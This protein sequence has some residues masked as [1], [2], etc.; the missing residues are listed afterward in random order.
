MKTQKGET[1]LKATF[2]VAACA[3]CAASLFATAASAQTIKIGTLW[4]YSG[5]NGNLGEIGEHGMRLYMQQHESD[6]PPGVKVKL[7]AGV[8]FT[9]NA[10]AIAPLATEAKMPFVVM[11]A[12]TSM[13]TTKSPFIVRT[14]FT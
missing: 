5:L 14:S 4:A 1:M 12:G 10:L 3:A 7:L 9:P 6:L 8:I 13:I 2:Y 11:N